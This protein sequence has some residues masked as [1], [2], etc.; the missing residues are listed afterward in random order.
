MPVMD[1]QEILQ[2]YFGYSSFRLQQ[3]K[4][5]NHVLQGQDTFVLM[6]TGGGKSLCY[7]IPALA[8][9]GTAIVISPLI[10]LMKD[11]VD[12]LRVNGVP[13]A[14]LNSSQ[15]QAEQYDIVASLQ[16]GHLKLLYIAPEK[17]SADKGSFLHVLKQIRVSLF[18]IDEAHCVSHWGH[19]FRPDYLF[20]NGL[21]AQFAGTPFIAL[22]ASA[23][24][25]TREDIVRQL[26]LT[27]PAILVSSFNRA[28]IH[29]YVQPK[30]NTAESIIRYIHEHPDDSGII[31]CLSRKATEDLAA[32]L[33]AHRIGAGY[34]HAGMAASERASVQDDFIKDRV[35]IMVATIAFG[36]GIDKSN[37]RFV[38]HADL[39]KNIESYYQET[40]RAGRDGLQSEAILF[41]SG[42]DVLKMK[43]FA[44]VEGN[45]EQ[46]YLMLKKLQQMA[47]FAEMQS[48]RRQYLMHYFGEAHADHCGS[49]DFC[50]SSFQAQ[51]V[52]EEAQ[53]LLSAVS[54]LQER[55]G[56]GIVVD[57]LRGSQ[58][59]KITAAMRDLPTYGK[60]SAYSKEYWK[61]LI[62]Q[63]T[64]QGLL[65]ESTDLYPVLRLTEGS[66]DVLFHN[67]KV[68]VQ[69]LT[70][71][72]IAVKTDDLRVYENDTRET[73]TDSDLFQ[74]LRQVR[75]E[76]AEVENVP[77]Y[78]I[79]SDA[80]LREMA[81]YFPQTQEELGQI[82]GLG[83]FKL[84]KYGH[85]FLKVIRTYCGEHHID[86]LI[87]RKPQKKTVRPKTPKENLS[88]TIQKTFHLYEEGNNP[89]EIA[90]I[91]KLSLITIEGHLADF[92][93]AGKLEPGRFLN[94]TQLSAIMQVAAAKGLLSLRAIKDVLG[95]DFSYFDIKIGIAYM[96]WAEQ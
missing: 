75:K 33:Q 58:G 92:V 25:I 84:E 21:K 51:D 22:T 54:R 18:A 20:L 5:V 55:H 89:E 39:P 4:A 12:A 32:K 36:M 38:I 73:T 35:R 48:C 96:K 2:Q 76:H 74:L 65:R 85:S 61:N 26:N 63:L 64:A 86:S 42:A 94:A 69:Q 60:G 43:R 66:N 7:Q 72:A 67:K 46:S 30:H 45:E 80:T 34:Y 87:S 82:S 47:D 13:A 1:P 17:L 83:I 23:D 93:A 70:Q 28:N 10:A 14:C 56:K 37:V 57:F 88:D 29:Y 24:Q 40:G 81:A 91:R 6:P 41:Y 19:D 53:K 71:K 49:C 68:L 16:A 79:F 27:N 8:L 9:A 59:L 90:R 77:P 78:V 15:T 95:D 11:Q 50:L 31:Y 44:L 62:R 3:E 52:T